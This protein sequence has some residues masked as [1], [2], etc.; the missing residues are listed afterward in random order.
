MTLL[1][2]QILLL[3][4]GLLF[5]SNTI[6]NSEKNIVFAFVVVY[7]LFSLLACVIV[8][9]AESWFL[10]REYKEDL[11][12]YHEARDAVRIGEPSNF[13]KV[14]LPPIDPAEL[15]NKQ[16]VERATVKKGSKQKDLE[17]KIS[18]PEN[19][20]H[21]KGY[22]KGRFNAKEEKIENKEQ[23][24]NKDNADHDQD[25]D[26]QEQILKKR[27]APAVP[28]VAAEK[29]EEED[30]APD[31]ASTQIDSKS[32]IGDIAEDNKFAKKKNEPP[33]TPHPKEFKKKVLL[34]LD[35]KP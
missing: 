11:K 3:F 23:N 15:G 35:Y 28:P 32:D 17:I 34:F 20:Q 9:I 33:H 29:Q 1:T 4:T 27:K 25:I 8:F 16:K 7:V 22:G 13:K 21:V 19:F 24:E 18:G 12:K 31:D 30:K 14:E 26:D 2:F 6:D 10:Y 5:G